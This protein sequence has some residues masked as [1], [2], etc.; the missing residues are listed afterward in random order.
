MTTEITI[1]ENNNVATITQLAP[2]AYNENK[3]S[4]DRCLQFGNT[5][6]ERAKTEG[7]SD[8]LDQEIAHF[9]EKSKKTLKKMNE[10]RSAVTQLFDTIRGAYTGLENEVDPAKSNTIPHQLQDLRNKY[11]A[12]K[13][14]E[15][16]AELRRR[17]LAQAVANAKAQYA[18]DV[19]N[20][21]TRQFNALIAL[22]CNRI[23][24]LDKSLT[25][26]NYAIVVDGLK[27]TSDQLPQ[28]WFKALHPEVLLPA[29]LS[30]EDARAIAA[31][32]KQKM[33]ER[34][35]EQ[36]SFEIST[37]R[38]EALDR[39]PSKRKELER[40]AAANAEEAARIKRELEERERK[41]A[42]K[43]AKEK[44]EREAQEKAAAELAAQKQEMDGLFGAAQA[45]VQEYQPKT[46]VKKRINVIGVEGFMPIVGMWWSQ[47]GCTLTI[48]ELTKIFSKQLTYC[49][50]LAN[51]K[52]N[53]M[54]IQSDN[55]E[56]VDDVKAK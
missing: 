2:Q 39:L 56:Y 35:A 11:A 43:R 20:D 31:G 53:P 26:E 12:K 23:I 5:L 8:A 52:N 15:Q 33:Q 3:L 24:E 55:I 46:Q 30:P 13:R 6:L 25:L 44:A 54:F 37:N 38:D 49:N 18:T 41:E 27:N 17:Q 45:Q 34:F 1:F 48:E 36:F 50:K 51:D 29:I 47:I 42:E 28:A 10:K 19:E 7:M 14:E 16:E 4:H 40:I 32:V 9:I 21:Y 22:T